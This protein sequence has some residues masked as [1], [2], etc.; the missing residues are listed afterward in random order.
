MSRPT[1]SEAAAK[2]PPAEH[3]G[4]GVGL[5]KLRGAAPGAAAAAEAQSSAQLS[6][7]H[8]PGPSPAP[9]QKLPISCPASKQSTPEKVGA[10]SAELA[11]FLCWSPDEFY[12]F[13][14]MCRV[15]RALA[16]NPPLALQRRV[17]GRRTLGTCPMLLLARS[18]AGHAQKIHC[19]DASTDLYP[20]SDVLHVHVQ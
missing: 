16:Q 6:S 14:V 2:E 5:W 1:V 15:S 17:A 10:D 18:V 13:C 7:S 8:L 9:L 12:A 3:S 4:W 11:A 19:L 20:L